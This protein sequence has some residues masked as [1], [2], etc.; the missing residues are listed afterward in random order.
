MGLGSMRPTFSDRGGTMCPQ[1]KILRCGNMFASHLELLI[2]DAAFIQDY[3]VAL[4]LRKQPVHTLLVMS[5][6]ISADV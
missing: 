6:V 4:R 5:D 3:T 2:G 1:L